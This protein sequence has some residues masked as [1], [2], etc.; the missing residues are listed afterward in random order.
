[1]PYYF[2]RAV[3]SVEFLILIYKNFHVLGKNTR[4]TRELIFLHEKSLVKLDLL[5]ITHTT[6][7]API[8][9]IEYGRQSGCLRGT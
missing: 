1:M 6:F 9:L 2:F 8:R 4:K 5:L 7:G 3:V